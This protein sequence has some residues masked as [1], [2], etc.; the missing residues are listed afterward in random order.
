MDPKEPAPAPMSTPDVSHDLQLVLT[1][2]TDYI[3]QELRIHLNY[4]ARKINKDTQ[5]QIE[6]TIGRIH[7]TGPSPEG[8]PPTNVEQ[9]SK[10]NDLGVQYFYE[11]E[12]EKASEWLETATEEN[13]ASLEAWNNLAMVYTAMNQTEKATQAFAHAVELDPDRAEILNNKGVLAFL[14]DD[15]EEALT[16]LEEANEEEELRI[17]T[18]LNLA[19]AYLSRGELTRAVNAW[20]LV[21]AIDPAQE[22]AVQHLRQY[23]Q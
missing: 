17:P 18:L 3:D 20:K 2:L 5:Q 14:K 16:L 23:Y 19:Q 13:P 4:F 8:V 1:R 15:A 22:E 12:L 10:H 7:K 11:G 21:T 6:R 9:S